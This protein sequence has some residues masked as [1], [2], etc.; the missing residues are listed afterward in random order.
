MASIPNE[1]IDQLLKG[2]KKPEDLLGEEGIL[3]DLTKRLVE[4]ALNAELD[5]H[6]GYTKHDPGGRGTGNSRN[7]KGK[8]TV[9]TGMGEM[10]I[11]TPRD[12]D[13]TFSPELIRK[14][15]R[16]FEGFDDKI[17]SMYAR[18]MTVRDIQGHLKDQYGVEVSPT[19]ISNVTA[20]V[21]D[22]VVAWQSRPL[23]SVYPIVYFDAL[24][25]K[26]R[27]DGPVSK[28]SVYLALG[29]N[30]EGEKELLGL[31]IAK[32]EG[33]KFWLNILT[34]LKNRGLEDILIAC[35]DG[36]KGF[37]EAIEAAYPQADVQLCIVHMVRHSLRFVPWKE[38]KAVAE[39]LRAIY[40]AATQEEAEAALKRFADRWDE[41]YPS[42]SVSWRKNW[43][44]IIPFFAHPKDIRKVIYTT[45]AIESLNSSLRKVT[46]NR[47]A[48]PNDE[49]VLKLLYLALQNIAKKWTMPVRDWK[50]ALNRFMIQYP[51]R[52]PA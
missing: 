20:A 51:G 15:Q 10:E 44:R 28:K 23:E 16:R 34:E 46:K 26:S 39:D 43:E 6:L 9:K 38:R 24:V 41:P 13:A 22:E 30:L 45:N 48:F 37:P 52:I 36:L 32:T 18:G 33:A 12:R 4:R 14:G 19:L 35:V 3:Q 17:T 5:T 7:G 21:W 25:I 27:D 50:K 49:A 47:G 42:I 1:L 40:A 8:K 31:W 11:A 2:Y 29:I